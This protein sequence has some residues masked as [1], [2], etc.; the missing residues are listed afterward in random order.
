MKRWGIDKAK[1]YISAAKQRAAVRKLH[2]AYV[3]LGD[4]IESS[5]RN[6][7]YFD[8][9]Q[10]YA[11]RAA[12][13]RVPSALTKRACRECDRYGYWACDDETCF[14]SHG[15]LHESV[16]TYSVAAGIPASLPL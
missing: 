6:A 8:N 14:S 11:A 16:P 12:L 5:N 7:D 2:A 9:E 13:A 4:L 10:L 1:S 3:A 15:C